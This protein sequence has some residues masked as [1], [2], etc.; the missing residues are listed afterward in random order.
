[1][2]IKRVLASLFIEGT[3]FIPLK[4]RNILSILRDFKF[5]KLGS[6]EIMPMT[7]TTKSMIFQESL[8]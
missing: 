2:V 8:R 4:G 7:T 6:K 5:G 1:M 3:A